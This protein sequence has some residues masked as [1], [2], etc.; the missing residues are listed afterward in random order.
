MKMFKQS[1]LHIQFIAG[2]GSVQ[3]VRC[4]LQP[5]MQQQA[6]AALQLFQNYTI[7]SSTPP[8]HGQRKKNMVQILTG[9][10]CQSA[11]AKQAPFCLH[12]T[13]GKV[14]LSCYALFGETSNRTPCLELRDGSKVKA[15]DTIFEN[16]V[17]C[18][19][20]EGTEVELTGYHVRV[21]RVIL[22]QDHH[23]RLKVMLPNAELQ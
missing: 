7:V 5:Q 13:A 19:S 11:L 8:T 9:Q 20:K 23:E 14:E 1:V 12:A 4:N 16:T 3:T 2:E 18:C 6:Q 22:E 10:C 21:S 17:V 15:T